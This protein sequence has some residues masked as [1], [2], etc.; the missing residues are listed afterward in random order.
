MNRTDPETVIGAWLEDGPTTLRHAARGPMLREILV[1]PQARP[2]RRWLRV[3]RSPSLRLA[4]AV[5]ALV[6]GLV[7]GSS[8]VPRLAS[9][10]PGPAGPPSPVPSGVAEPREVISASVFLRGFGYD[11]PRGEISLRIVSGHLVGYDAGEYEV[12]VW[13]VEEVPVDPCHSAGLRRPITG[14]GG[15]VDYLRGVQGLEVGPP[16]E[17]WVDGIR[18]TDLRLVRAPGASCLRVDYLNDPLSGTTASVSREREARL[19]V[20]E[21][22]GRVVVFDAGSRRELDAWLPEVDAFL[23]SIDFLPPIERPSRS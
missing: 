17:R 12:Q 21:V 10:P 1:T 8:I 4:L 20:L 9:I 14:A 18:A 5:S 3:G 2:W 22:D 7:L 16:A 15:F 23:A 19:T 13:L 6:V 11:K